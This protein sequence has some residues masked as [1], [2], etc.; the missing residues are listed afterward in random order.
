MKRVAAWAVALAVV[1]VGV[2]F[3]RA[4]LM[5]VRAPE[6]PGSRTEFV[7][8]ADTRED[9]RHLRE[10]TRG[11]VSVC[12]LLVNADVVEASFTPLSDDVFTF[13][14]EPALGE[15]DTREMRGCLQDARV[16]HLQVDVRDVDHH[17]PSEGAGDSTDAGRSR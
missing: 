8:H 15:F 7:V 12:R 11:L 1:A 4:E 17:V 10:M 14:V 2:F 3:L 5:T 9:P 16:Q 13:A 6:Q